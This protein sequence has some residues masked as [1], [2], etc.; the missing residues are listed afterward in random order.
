MNIPTTQQN[1]YKDGSSYGTQSGINFTGSGVTVSN[2][3]YGLDV[4]IAG[5]SGLTLSNSDLYSSDSGSQGSGSYN[6]I[7]GTGAAGSG[8]NS[9]SYNIFQGFQAGY[10]NGSGNYNDF[11]GAYAGYTSTGEGNDFIG[12]QSGYANYGGSYNTALGYN[13]SVSSN[14]TNATAIGANAV[15][16]VSNALVLGD[17]NTT[18][19][20][21]NSSPNT[22]NALDVGG[23][24]YADEV[25]TS[26]GFCLNSL[27]DQ[28]LKTDVTPLDP[29]T[30]EKIL[31]LNPVSFKWNDEY[32][33]NHKNLADVSDT[34]IGFIAQDMDKVFPE[35]VTHGDNG[36]LGIDYSKLTSVLTEGIKELYT[37]V[38]SI[39]AEVDGMMKWF[40]NGNLTVQNNICVDDICVTKEQFK[41][42]LR[43]AGGTNLVNTPPPTPAPAPIPT[44]IPTPTPDPVT[45]VPTTPSATDTN[46]NINSQSTTSSPDTTTPIITLNGDAAVTLTVGTA[47][48][49][50]G[51]KAS[52]NIDGDI[53][54]NIQ[55][56]GT[57]DTTTA[58]TYTLTYT[59]SDAAGNKT[60]A[61]RTVTVA[62]Q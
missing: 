1:Y 29:D 2:S 31:T 57:V 36:L 14:L 61:T 52:D 62:A 39:K 43:N 58:G 8:S 48:T 47:Y 40:Q 41:Q 51:A 45:T 16:N 50:A 25:C 20:I 17:A 4:N 12:Y 24:I 53:S 3:G 9:G 60:I 15:V 28:S 56:A 38:T 5:G 27:S 37:L 35:V 6:F 32:I 55:T 13:T 44:T 11:Q 22:N 26:Q 33:K 10:L 18:V 34:K 54:A 21:R 23:T 46:T 30:L 59:V 42:M 19:G 7:I 49:D